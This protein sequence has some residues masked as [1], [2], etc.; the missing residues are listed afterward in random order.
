MRRKA[1]EE[2]LAGLKTSV[3]EWALTAHYL[4]AGVFKDKTGVTPLQIKRQDKI[5]A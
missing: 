2:N 5:K 1:M 3:S 4:G